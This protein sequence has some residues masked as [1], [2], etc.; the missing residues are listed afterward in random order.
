VKGIRI[1]VI[2]AVLC[3]LPLSVVSARGAGGVTWGQEFFYPSLSGDSTQAN[4]SGAYGYGVSR[5]GTRFGGFAISLNSSIPSSSFMGG[6]VGFISG[7]EVHLGPVIGALNLWTG[8]GGMRASPVMNTPDCFALFGELDLEV[9]FAFTRGM[10]LTGYA[11]VQG[12]TGLVDGQP[13]F[14]N[15]MWAPVLGLRLAFGSF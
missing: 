5:D 13:L 11:G 7:Q 4:F 6:F 9:G 2:A 15:V 12:I 3:V 10:E 1:V 14:H 8:I